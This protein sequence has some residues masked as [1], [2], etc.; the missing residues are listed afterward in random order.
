M[1]AN[2]LIRDPSERRQ[3]ARLPVEGE[4]TLRTER[5]PLDVIVSDLSESGCAIEAPVELPV[6]AE[7]SIGLVGFGA[8][9]A[10]VVR[11]S[12][13]SHG[14]EFLRPIAPH[15]VRN[16]FTSSNVVAG[17]VAHGAPQIDT[18]FPEPVVEKWHPAVRLAVLAGAT[19]AL[20]S[21]IGA[22]IF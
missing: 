2:V 18:D 8:F 22:L 6:G 4:S 3:S 21:I 1:L 10:R 14:C 5:A 7:I 19:I 11:R 12:G 13:K 15:I 16:A 17:P 20:W 9:E